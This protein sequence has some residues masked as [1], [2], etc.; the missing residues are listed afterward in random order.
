MSIELDAVVASVRIGAP[1]AICRAL[2]PTILAFSNLVI[3]GGPIK[4]L[5]RIL[6]S[7]FPVFSRGIKT[8]SGSISL[9]IRVS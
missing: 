1:M 3:R 6:Y 2:A 4:M 5:V 8:V 7:P 9:R